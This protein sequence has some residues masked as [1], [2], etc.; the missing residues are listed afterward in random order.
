MAIHP[1][2]V[3]VINDVFSPGP[4]E[5]A[6]CARLIA[7]VEQA[8]A[9]GQGAVSFEGQMVDEAMAATARLVLERHSSDGT[10]TP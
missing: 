5:L 2:H 9:R 10:A 7:A 1:S 3:P 8:Q 4:E 6:R